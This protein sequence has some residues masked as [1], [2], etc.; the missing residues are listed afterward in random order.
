MFPDGLTPLVKTVHGLGMEFGLWFE[1]EMVNL[2]SDVA[3]AHPEWIL[4]THAGPGISSRNQHVLDLPTRTP[5][6]T[7]SVR[8]RRW[9]TA[10]ASPTSSG[11]TTVP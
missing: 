9:S 8:S 11:T 6:T 4:G 3:R 1:P 10:T 7:C 5:G 2:D